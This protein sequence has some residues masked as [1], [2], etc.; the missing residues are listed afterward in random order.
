[1]A[2]AHERILAEV[3][4]LLDH[5]RAND[6]MIRLE[7]LIG[8]LG[9]E[10]LQLLSPDLRNVID[11]FYPKKKRDLQRRL[12]ARLG[13]EDSTSSTHDTEAIL[14][15]TLENIR[16]DYGGR[17]DLL[18]EHHIFQWNTYYRETIGYIFKDLM[19]RTQ[20]ADFPDKILLAASYEFERHSADIYVQG[21]EY[22][23]Q[24]HNLS[25]S[26][27]QSKSLGGLQRFLLLLVQEH[28]KLTQTVKH[29]SDSQTLRN[30]CSTLL[31]GVLIGYSKVSYGDKTGSSLLQSQMPSWAHALA[32]LRGSDL[33]RL[34]APADADTT[35]WQDVKEIV[36][37]V[38][39]ALDRLFDKRQGDD[40][41][42]TRVSRFTAIPLRLE[43]SLALPA[44]ATRQNLTLLCYLEGPYSERRVVEEPMAAG[45]TM[46]C[47]RMTPEL[48]K[49]SE[50]SLPEDTI[51]ASRI[52]SL[53]EHSHSISSLCLSILEKQLTAALEGTDD[54]GAA[55]SQ[56][57][58]SVSA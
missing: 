46:V 5:N 40:F 49:W 36:L 31:T 25:D 58:T 27:A 57:R 55:P 34:V 21:F 8:G 56:L 30:V 12:D 6:A 14:A 22:I 17:L 42:L 2:V 51:D 33:A 23:T 11:R 35:S 7:E 32:F 3:V 28:V 16:A 29:A 52:G 4:S 9:P 20:L 18:R 37:P 26:V 39:V 54:G 19:Q 15:E 50:E 45:V 24:K 47:L 13:L 38:F 48:R 53:P 1:M 43:F 44:R 10:R 41:I